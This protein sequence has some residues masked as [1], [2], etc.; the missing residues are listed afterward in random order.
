MFTTV[1][2]NIFFIEGKAGAWH[3]ILYMK[4]DNRDTYKL[5]IVKCFYMLRINKHDDS[6]MEVIYGKYNTI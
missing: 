5:C 4:V 3:V 1:V 2:D 6:M